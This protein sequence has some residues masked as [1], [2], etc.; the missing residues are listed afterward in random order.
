[1]PSS[2]RLIKALQK[3][4][5]AF[6]NLE[7]QRDLAQALLED[8]ERLNSN[9]RVPQ[10]NLSKLEAT[11]KEYEAAITAVIAPS[12]QPDNRTVFKNKITAQM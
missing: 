3:E 8:P 10:S 12:E 5:D 6:L 9:I 1:M 11:V 4:D 2:Q 7:T